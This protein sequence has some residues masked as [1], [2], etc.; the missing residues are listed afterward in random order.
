[1]AFDRSRLV[2]I[3]FGAAVLVFRSLQAVADPPPANY[4]ET[5]LPGYTLPDPLV[6]SD[7]RPVNSAEL[8]REKRRPEILELFRQHMYGCAP[9]RPASRLTFRELEQSDT[10]FSGRAIRKQIR[11]YFL[12]DE[13]GPHADLLIYLPR[14]QTRPTPLF[15]SLNFFGN[16]TVTSDPAV[17]L[18]TR[19][20][21]AHGEAVV[22]NRAT[23][24]SRG[25]HV[26]RWPIADILERGYGVATMYSG[27]IDPDSPDQFESGIRAAIHPW[28]D[29]KQCPTCGRGRAD[30]P[31]CSNSYHVEKK[32]A[33]GTIAAWAWGLSR[34]M[35][36]FETDRDIDAKHVAVLGHSRLGKT[37]LWAGAEDERFAIVISNDSGCGGA[38]LSRRIYGETVEY[39][40]WRFP[41]WFCENFKQYGP[42]VN[43]LPIDQHML[44]ALIAPRPVYIASAV[45][46][47]WADP[48]GEFLSALHAGPVYRLLG[49]DDLA[50]RDL[51]PLHA[52]IMSTI[53]YHIRS[54]VHDITPYDWKCF[55]SFADKHWQRAA[56]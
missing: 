29:V 30:N 8:W 25:T 38:A 11:L 28:Q 31:E 48:H 56:K 5:K 12:G 55:M 6:F 45:E 17:P 13:K 42:R 18:S 19:W 44:V 52:P 15:L 50:N 49:A 39:I 14:E 2:R 37:A 54:G 33:W 40:N 4:D 36:Y 3:S 32:W 21:P 51:P 1:M 23:P 34:A 24:A 41:H 53:G 10:A 27:D 35:D 46:D 47:R 43:D 20:I 16:H 7:G 9:R 22:N 26:A